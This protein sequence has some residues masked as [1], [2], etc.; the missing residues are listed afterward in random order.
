MGGDRR[1]P[2]GK[3]ARTRGRGSSPLTNGSRAV[4]GKAK[5]RKSARSRSGSKRKKRLSRRSRS[6]NVSVGR[7]RSRG[8]GGLD[9]EE[10][11][12]VR[13]RQPSGSRKPEEDVSPI[14][15]PTD[16]AEPEL[17]NGVTRCELRGRAQVQSNSEHNSSSPVWRVAG[18]LDKGDCDDGWVGDERKIDGAVS[19]AGVAA[20]SATATGGSM[21][22]AAAR[23]GRHFDSELCGGDGASSDGG[24]VGRSEFVS[25]GVADANNPKKDAMS[26]GCSGKHVD[27]SDGAANLVSGSLR[28]GGTL[29]DDLGTSGLVSS[30]KIPVQNRFIPSVQPAIAN[31]ARREELFADGRA[32]NQVDAA[33]GAVDTS[34]ETSHVPSIS[35]LSSGCVKPELV[36]STVD[37]SCISLPTAAGTRTVPSDSGCTTVSANTAVSDSVGCGDSGGSCALTD[38]AA[39]RNIACIAPRVA[40]GPHG[41]CSSFVASGLAAPGAL[42]GAVHEGG[43]PQL[44][45]LPSVPL[46]ETT[47]VTVMV[48]VRVRAKNKDTLRDIRERLVEKGLLNSNVGGDGEPCGPF[49]ARGSPV[50]LSDETEVRDLPDVRLILSPEA[51][52]APWQLR[53]ASAMRSSNAITGNV[54]GPSWHMQMQMQMQLQMQMQMRGQQLGPAQMQHLNH[55]YKTRICAFWSQSQG[56]CSKGARCIYAHGPGELR[57]RGP[58][59]MPGGGM[60]PGSF[61]PLLAPGP[62]GGSPLGVMGR[63]MGVVV[64]PGPCATVG[65]C[66]GGI[67]ALVPPPPRP[68]R[69]C[70]AVA[71]AAAAAAARSAVTPTGVQKFAEPQEEQIVYTVDEEERRRREQR[72]K[73][74]AP[75]AASF[76]LEAA[77]E[78]TSTSASVV[79]SDNSVMNAPSVGAESNA[80]DG[81]DAG[82]RTRGTS[83]CL[84]TD[85]EAVR[86]SAAEGAS[87]GGVGMMEG[88]DGMVGL[89]VSDEIFGEENIAD[90]LLEMQQQYLLGSPMA[91]EGPTE[92][93]AT[94]V[95]NADG[96]TDEAGASL[97]ASQTDDA[98]SA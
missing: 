20:V 68:N 96:S 48:N 47:R 95:S 58:L 74:F 22:V 50:D 26:G 14:A 32:S 4:E 90:F 24:S 21:G 19:S 77:N 81:S 52:L 23:W 80:I 84:A 92:H 51:G 62:L 3:R 42:Q 34:C 55:L 57:S 64:P 97:L 75:R 70:A 53:L 88:F 2:R 56:Y 63:P 10:E 73:R 71:I 85:S 13:Q 65:G 38:D 18:G 15:K 6:K 89:D 91:D 87:D 61:R 66:G 46:P 9:T 83:G 27:R 44:P 16:H 1:S 5:R 86:T 98:L 11:C 76:D 37:P 69:G 39:T 17:V 49:R 36:G 45:A 7:S 78:Q 40:P 67:S 60:V 93:A 43:V 35:P 28:H 33:V 41:G 94:S 31:V 59:S 30:S 29:P 79:N 82:A 54:G 12:R 72:A 25:G 8:T